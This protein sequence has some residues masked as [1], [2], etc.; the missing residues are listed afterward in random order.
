MCTSRLLVAFVPTDIYIYIMIDPVLYR[1][2]Q[3]C[4]VLR[5]L[6]FPSTDLCMSVHQNLCIYSCCH[7]HFG[8]KRGQDTEMNLWDPK[9]SSYK[10]SEADW[11]TRLKENGSTGVRWCDD[12]QCLC[13]FHTNGKMHQK[14]TSIP[15]KARWAHLSEGLLFPR[16]PMPQQKPGAG[17]RS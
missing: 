5:V 10:S 13:T 4:R 9:S 11:I 2:N 16:G 6:C 14:V 12:L 7:A 15:F 17:Y 3:V 8:E 1:L